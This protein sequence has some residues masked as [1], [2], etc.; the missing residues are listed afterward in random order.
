MGGSAEIRLTWRPSADLRI[1]SRGEII[2][3]SRHASWG[4]GRQRMAKT[5]TCLS[6]LHVY[7]Q[8]K[9]TSQRETSALG[10]NMG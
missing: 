2:R 5:V 6:F 9:A 4:L 10:R 3:P 8:D 1:Q 7:E